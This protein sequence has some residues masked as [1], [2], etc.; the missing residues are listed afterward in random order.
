MP[1][2]FMVTKPLGPEPGTF[3]IIICW[4][5]LRATGLIPWYNFYLIIYLLVYLFCS[6]GHHT[7]GLLCARQVLYH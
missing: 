1:T 2:F 3:Y 7:Q 6:D 4:S 5:P